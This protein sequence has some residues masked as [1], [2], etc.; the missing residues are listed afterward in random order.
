MTRPFV[1]L[2]TPTYN[3]RLFMP[4]AIRN[5]HSQQYPK[6]RIEWIIAD[7]GND[8]IKD[9]IEDIPQVRYFEFDSKMSLGKKRNFLN[10][11]ANGDIIISFDDDDWYSKD[12]VRKMVDLLDHSQ[13]LIAGSSEVYN[14]FVDLNSIYIFGPYGKFHSCN[15]MLCYKK[16]Y[17]KNHSYE[18]E[19][20]AQEEP[21]FTNKF[22]EPM[23]QIQNPS[24]YNLAISH[25]T[26]SFDRRM[27]IES[28]GGKLC[29]KTK[30]KLRNI[31]RDK[32]AIKFYRSLKTT[33]Y[34]DDGE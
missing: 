8:K 14:Y 26:N 13:Y 22:T 27:N 20:K 18:D 4:Q 9:M 19:K 17:L 3:R 29:R 2:I 6:D 1:S 10:S 34:I 7:D 28:E 25:T 32:Q 21:G 23:I 12:Y 30:L 24:K 5:F 31:I 15:G 11:K 16:E 33:L